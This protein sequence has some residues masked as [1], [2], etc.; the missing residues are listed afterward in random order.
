MLATNI[1]SWSNSLTSR[2]TSITRPVQTVKK[3][4]KSQ[5]VILL[6]ESTIHVFVYSQSQEKRM[7]CATWKHFGL[8]GHVKSL[9]GNQTS[10][11]EQRLSF[12]DFI[13]SILKVVKF[14]LKHPL[15]WLAGPLAANTLT[16]AGPSDRPGPVDDR[17]VVPRVY[18]VCR[19]YNNIKL[20]L[21]VAGPLAASTPTSAGPSDTFLGPCTTASLPSS[22]LRFIRNL[23]S[24]L[25][26]PKS[27]LE[28]NYIFL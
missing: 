21:Q 1:T 12:C 23:M 17:F 18:A 26:T 5:L 11:M 27:H 14:S 20:N 7:C 24:W 16:S 2:S 25:S 13:G 22:S 19:G 6:V 28:Q 9:L 4:M 3:I 15:C 8:S 10:P